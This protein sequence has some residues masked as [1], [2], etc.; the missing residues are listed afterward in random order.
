M[1]NQN[2]QRFLKPNR[3]YGKLDLLSVEWAPAQTVGDGKLVAS[4]QPHWDGKQFANTC[5]GCHCTGVDPR[6]RAFSALGLD[7]YTCHGLVDLKHS[8]DPSL[9]HLSKKRKDPAQ[10][11]TSICGQCH[12]RTGASVVSGLPYPNNFV[13]GDNL[14]RDF[15]VDFSSEAIGRLNPAD[16][17]VL[18]NIREVVLFGQE[19]VTC[20]S[21]HDV[22]QQSTKKHRAL[23]QTESC[24]S[25][26]N[27]TGSKKI[28]KAYE[29]H[30]QVCGY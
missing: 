19:E 8:K 7:C 26:H 9:V 29:V 25:C 24:L 28:R 20:L 2:R 6:T 22:H 10:I 18:E 12:V 13:A 16:R 5:A 4:A 23:A 21:C 1:G 11:V 14:F 30:S 15:R 27:Q 17:H 3:D